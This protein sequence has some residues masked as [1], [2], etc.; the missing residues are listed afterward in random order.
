MSLKLNKEQMEAVLHKDGPILVIAGAG[1]GK[2]RVVASRIKE[3]INSGIDE[4]KILGLTFTN[5]AALELKERVDTNGSK[6]RVSTFHSLGLYILRKY[7]RYINRDIISVYD[8]SDSTSVIK[9]VLAEL[10]IDKSRAKEFLSVIRSIKENASFVLLKEF[11]NPSIQSLAEN[12]NEK[13]EYLNAYIKYEQ[14]C[15]DNK[16]IDFSDIISITICLINNTDIGKRVKEQWDYVIVDEY[17]DTSIIE[18][19]FLK[20][21]LGTNNLMVVG[22]PNQ[23][24]YE[25]RG[26]VLKHIL[27]FENKYNEVKIVKLK[28][29]Y[30]STVEILE[31]S[32]AIVNCSSKD[33]IN[34]LVSNDSC[35]ERP[36]LCVFTDD[37][38]EAGYIATLAKSMHDKGEEVAILYR[39]N[40]QSRQLEDALSKRNVSYAIKGSI[41]MYERSEIKTMIAYLRC[42]INPN[43]MLAFERAMTHPK[44]GLG[45][46]FFKKIQ[47]ICIKNN[48]NIKDL[49]IDIARDSAIAKQ[50]GVSKKQNNAIVEFVNF[51][52][53]AIKESNNNAGRALKYIYEESGIKEYFA[54]EENGN[55]KVINMKSF[56]MLYKSRPDTIEDL[57]LQVATQL[58]TNEEISKVI[59][60]TIH[61]AK[62]LEFDNVF[63]CGLE[64]GLLPHFNAFS[65][66]EERRLLYVASTRAKKNLILTRAKQR[67]LNGQFAS[68]KTTRFLDGVARNLYILKDFSTD[69]EYRPYNAFNRFRNI[70]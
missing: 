25:W 64:E 66:D 15:R 69:T 17:Q 56:Y 16:A 22:D 40:S 8:E 70:Y 46:M 12:V 11:L 19:L 23:S 41:S 61:S 43:D 44:R 1:S 59:L 52:E 36:K 5:K 9:K 6:V 65:I 42:I 24:I 13:E 32:N 35:G 58:V 57:V 45:A 33:Y 48:I 29:N 7:S 53:E 14:I 31:F 10:E 18:E 54:S 27:S 4:N 26:A 37:R 63:V 67:F 20:S 3:L 34:N 55:N 21:V 60:M 2:T 30:R 49:F 51:L 50:V 28:T 39:T 68:N 47:D 38:K 62:G